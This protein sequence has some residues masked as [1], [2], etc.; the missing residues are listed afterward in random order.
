MR[1]QFADLNLLNDPTNLKLFRE[2]APAEYMP[3][4]YRPDVHYP[5]SGPADPAL[6]SDLVFIGSAFRSRIEFFEAMNLTGLDVLLGGADWGSI[7]PGSPL[8]PFVGTLPGAPDCVD[9]PQAAGLYRHAR[10]GINFYRREAE[11]T[12][13]GHGVAMGPREVEMAACGLFFLRDPRPESDE[14]FPMLP[15]F[16]GPEDAAEKLRWWLTRDG[17]R[18]KRAAQAREAIEGRTFEANAKRFLELAADL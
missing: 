11:E 14:V 2:W 15:S 7:E 17:L 18:D 6:A 10:A 9:N 4:A 1:G 16:D 3:H 8:V 12:W 5:R 13:T